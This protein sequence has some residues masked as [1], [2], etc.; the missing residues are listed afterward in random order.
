MHLVWICL[1]IFFIKWSLK[2][3]TRSV[4]S[5]MSVMSVWS[6]QYEGLFASSNKD[7]DTR[8]DGHVS[9]L[10]SLRRGTD[11]HHLWKDDSCSESNT[12]IS[13]T[14]THTHTH[15]NRNTKRK[16]YL[17]G[18]KNANEHVKLLKADLPAGIPVQHVKSVHYLLLPQVSHMVHEVVKLDVWGGRKRGRG[19][20]WGGGG[21]HEETGYLESTLRFDTHLF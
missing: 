5:S 4:M 19:R 12:E 13:P 2:P 10:S 3:Q 17:T 18:E 1:S 7:R 20:G 8:Q 15:T 11:Y 21:L 9:I 16:C 6:I 14:C